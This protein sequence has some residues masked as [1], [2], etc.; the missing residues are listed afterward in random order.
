MPKPS[1]RQAIGRVLD[2]IDDAITKTEA[3]IAKLKQVRTGM[4]HDMLSYGLDEYGQLRDPVAHPEQFKDS[5]VGLIPKA[6]KTY[7]LENLCSNIGSGVTPRGGQDVY[8]QEGILFVRSQNVLFDG[9]KLEDIAFI[10]RYIH[11]SMLR[12]AVFA[13]DVLFNITGASIG[14]CCVV[15]HGLGKA[16]V[17]QHVC[18]LRIPDAAEVDAIFLSTVLA[19]VIGQKQLEALNTCGNRQGLNYQQLGSFTVPWPEPQERTL[20]VE[21][22][23][24]TTVTLS[25][26]IDEIKKLR[27][28]IS[29]LQDD[30]LTGRVRV[31]E[32]IMEEGNGE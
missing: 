4:L 12:S 17:N 1:Q 3:V 8:T 30:L 13:H 10:P 26:E 9:L 19:S 2:T 28:L 23:K 14:R 27:L 20:I 15:P 32:T 11:N 21:C 5:P 29:G 31:P 22:V 16:N 18:I 7:T 6:W 24:H 25:A